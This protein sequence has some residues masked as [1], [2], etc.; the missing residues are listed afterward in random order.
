M[1]IWDKRDNVV[2]HDIKVEEKREHPNNEKQK[3]ID[4]LCKM[5][6]DRKVGQYY[7]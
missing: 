1:I 4:A 6:E 2:V 7:V 3:E 5:L